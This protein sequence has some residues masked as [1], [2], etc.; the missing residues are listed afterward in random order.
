MIIREM[1]KLSK[2]TSFSEG[3]RKILELTLPTGKEKLE[4]RIYFCIENMYS[5]KEKIQQSNIPDDPVRLA[6][7]FIC[8][9]S[10]RWAG[11]TEN[12]RKKLEEK[13]WRDLLKEK[14]IDAFLSNIYKRKG[15]MDEAKIKISKFLKSLENLELELKRW[16]ENERLENFKLKFQSLLDE[17]GIGRKGRDNILRDCGYIECIPIDI[18]EQRFLIRTGIFHRYS[19]LENSDPTDYHHLANA[20]RNFC[21]KELN[22]LKIDDINLADAP[23]V[24][25]MIIWYFSQER[26]K[27]EISLKIC[28][29]RPRCNECPLRENLCLYAKTQLPK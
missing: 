3:F 17:A 4:D 13:N 20:L 7:S 9:R 24:V 29:K 16:T 11:I 2:I 27:Q 25:D 5:N 10:G 26:T 15:I 12:V 19:T 28:A 8:G 22:G 1:I 18:H 23:G 14:E 6:I 21:K